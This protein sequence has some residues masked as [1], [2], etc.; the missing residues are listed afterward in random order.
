LVERSVLVV[1]DD[2]DMRG[3][4]EAALR[5]VGF[6]SHLTASA[7]EALAA[8][9]GDDFDVVIADFQM[10]GMN[11]LELCER[12]VAARPDVP[13]VVLTAHG[14]VETAIGAIRAGAY[15]FVLKPFKLQP[16]QLVIE[17]AARYR[18]LAA[19]VRRLREEASPA[20]FG[21]I[22]GQSPPMRAVFDLIARVAA[23]DSTVLVTGESG[24]GKELVARAIHQRSRRAAGPFVAINC[25]AVPETLLES[26]LFG[27]TKGAFTDARTA[28]AGLF[29]Q[30]SGGTLFLDEIGETPPAV[31]AKL[32]RVLQERVVR[33]VGGDHEVPF[34][35]RVVAA[36][37]RD[38]E[39]AVEE[40]RFRQD[41]LWRIQVVRVELP[42]LR[43]RGNDI[44]VLAQHAIERF[45][46][47]AA[48]QVT[49]LSPAAAQKLMAYAWP[50]NVRELNNAIERAVALTRYAELTVDDLPER[51][52]D[53]QSSQFIVA[54]EDPE[55]LPPMEEV[56]RRYV[57][58]VL[59]S[60]Q[61]NK[62][63]AARILGFDRKTLYRKLERYGIGSDER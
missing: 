16:F 48:K 33:P 8:L 15:D 41:L 14:T 1:D 62:A 58:R 26:E 29:L 55:L 36:T 49:G 54:G 50:G 52:R 45:A 9:P 19:E 61:G 28:R 7:E 37:N 27:H 56:E 21:A 6:R 40:G 31:Q 32:L 63:L 42:P 35:A 20:S 23:T 25:A 5:E 11:G 2:P 22:V 39:A 13:V 30:A 60:V 47:A 24:T 38:L 46:R 4:V 57:L 12:I 59:E 53:Y 3:L 10:P 17:R 34:D 43:L 51:V 18:E 44:L